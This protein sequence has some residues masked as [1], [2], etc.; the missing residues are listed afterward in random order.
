MPTAKTYPPDTQTTLEDS[1]SEAC[2]RDQPLILLSSSGRIFSPN[3]PGEYP[4][5]QD[6]SWM[7]QVETGSV[8]RLSFGHFELEPESDC[9]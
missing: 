7:I 8:I 6:C 2:G 4:S 1:L 9:E 3:Y 5:N